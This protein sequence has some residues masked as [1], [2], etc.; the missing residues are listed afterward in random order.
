MTEDEV[1]TIIKNIVKKNFQIDDDLLDSEVIDSMMIV[2]LVI[3]FEH[4]FGCSIPGHLVSE[5]LLTPRTVLD[6]IKESK[7]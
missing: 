6:Y 2:R 7:V 4:S 5:V 3:E 1:L